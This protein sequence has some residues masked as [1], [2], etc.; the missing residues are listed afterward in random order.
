MDR[1]SYVCYLLFGV[2]FL[3]DCS[4]LQLALPLSAFCY[5]L[6][7]AKPSRMYWQVR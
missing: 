4:L 2:A 1:E 7:S 3:S 5:A 6:V